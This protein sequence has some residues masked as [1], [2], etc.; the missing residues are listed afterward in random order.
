MKRP[1]SCIHLK[2]AI[3]DYS[4]KTSGD[5]IR[6]GR[7]MANVVLGQML[8]DGVVKGGSSLLFRYG[9]KGTRYTKD[10]DTA[11]VMEIAPYIDR[12]NAAL[13]SGWHGF[14]GRVVRVEPPSPEGV[15]SA[16]LM[17]P[18]DV[19]LNYC[20][21]P[22]MTIRIEIGHN[23]IGDADEVECELA[24]DMVRVFEELGFPR[25]NKIPVMKLSYQIAQKLHAATGEN[26]ER[27]H[28]LVDLQL[29][30]AHS[31]IDL[32]ETGTLCRRLFD[33]RRRQS[34]PPTIVKG[35][36][37]DR[38]YAEACANIVGTAPVLPT[39]DEAVAWA[40]D[41]INRISAS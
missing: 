29:I 38:L 28:D 12:L 5:E 3:R 37:W 20:N 6:L 40:N 41:L 22:W 13:K 27:A 8:P 35:V 2:N 24:D 23:E 4:V 15:P 25:P 10:V 32:E 34:W 30:C 33:Y 9:G 17:L 14:S 39:V 26:S 1:N 7:A 31:E 19:K 21:K 16:Y 36:D 11:R 18:Y